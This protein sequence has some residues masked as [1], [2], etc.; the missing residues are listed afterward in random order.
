MKPNGTTLLISDAFNLAHINPDFLPPV[1]RIP[2]NL[3]IA[4]VLS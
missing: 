4:L 1:I 3:E 2:E